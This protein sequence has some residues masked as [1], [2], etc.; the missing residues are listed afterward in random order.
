MTLQ[1]DYEIDSSINHGNDSEKISKR[2]CIFRN[3]F[4]SREN[5]NHN[6]I[7]INLQCVC[8]LYNCCGPAII[9][10]QFVETP[11]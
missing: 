7:F 2:N 3:L 4:V 8:V 10:F 11:L 9:K 6:L 5:K 1:R